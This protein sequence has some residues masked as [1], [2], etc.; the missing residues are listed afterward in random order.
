MISEKSLWFGLNR[1]DLDIKDADVAVYGVPFEDAVSYRR[2]TKFGPD[3]VRAIDTVY[4]MTRNGINLRSLK[5]VDTGDIDVIKR[6][7]EA[8]HNNVRKRAGEIISA[9]ALPLMIGGDHS[10]SFPAIGSFKTK[11]DNI[12]VIWIDA[13]ADV[14]EKYDGS[15]LSHAC[16]LRR[17]IEAGI[18]RPEHVALVGIRMIH[19]S[20]F[21]Y[22]QNQQ[23]LAFMADDFEDQEVYNI[24]EKICQRL[25]GMPTYISFDIDAIDP[26][27]APG[28]GIPSPG[29]LT[30]REVFSLIHE[31]VE[32]EIIGFDV[33]EVS[34]FDTTDVT[35]LI[36]MQFICEMFGN[37]H[38][39][40][41]K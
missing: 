10:L 29:G 13:H 6:D 31:L 22:I 39:R 2:G 18:V 19:E 32:L 1:P 7:I 26:S 4:P 14:F 25:Y 27:H 20:E 16:P 11:F 17:I 3:A 41:L 40:K 38:Q 21:E 33:V 8:T 35:P 12:G 9:G 28:T 15:V 37:I 24:S 5:I 30:P 36:A 34:H 23:L